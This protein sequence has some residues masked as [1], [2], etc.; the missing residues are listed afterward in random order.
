MDRSEDLEI[1]R[2]PSQMNHSAHLEPIDSKTVFNSPLKETNNNQILE[3]LPDEYQ[4][5]EMSLTPIKDK[6]GQAPASVQI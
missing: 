2:K 5:N 6:I 3:P 4:S 1:S